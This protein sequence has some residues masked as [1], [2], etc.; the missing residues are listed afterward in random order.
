MK[1]LEN[2]VFGEDDDTLML[3]VIHVWELFV[4]WADSLI[5]ITRFLNRQYNTD[6]TAQL[7]I[8]ANGTALAIGFG[9]VAFKKRLG[10]DTSIGLAYSELFMLR[11]GT[12]PLIRDWYDKMSEY[13]VW[14]NSVNPETGERYPL[15]EDALSMID[16]FLETH[17]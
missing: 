6:E 10:E 15:H 13:G 3:F 11:N 2:E 17:N 5:S 9:S 14:M 7:V 8:K 1:E 16:E 4:K 12:I